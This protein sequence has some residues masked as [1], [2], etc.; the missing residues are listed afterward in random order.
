MFDSNDN[1]PISPALRALLELFATELSEVRFPDVDAEVLDD[2]AA[3]VRAKAEAVAKAQAALDSARLALHESQDALLQKGQRALA[4]ARVFSEENAELSAKLEGISLPR[5]TRKSARVE[6]AVAEPATAT[7][8]SDEN[9]PRR[10]GRPPKARTAAGGSLFADGAT[11]E[12][13][14]NH[15]HETG[16]GVLP[17]A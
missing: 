12:A 14:A 6:G 13:L 7:A 2:A 15:A 8:G 1:D 3:A 17:T 5:A 11:P 16:N 4:Y 10:R 9:A